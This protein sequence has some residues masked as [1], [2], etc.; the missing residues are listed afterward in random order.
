MPD[1]IAVPE[2]FTSGAEAQ[3]AR[4]H[5]QAERGSVPEIT[6]DEDL[7]R[8]DPGTKYRGPDNVVRTKPFIIKDDTDFAKVPEGAQYIGPDDVLRTKP[9][10]E[11]IGFT[12]QT[13]YGMAL[14][15]QGREK[16]LR[17]VYGDKVRKDDGGLYVD[18]DGKLRRPGAR[19]I[20]SALGV[21]AAETLP[22]VGMTVGSGLGGV[23]GLETGPGAAG[24]AFGG[25][26]L[27]AML[28][29]QANNLILGLAGIHESLPVQIESI[30]TEGAAVAGGEVLGKTATKTIKALGALP[31]IN[32][33]IRNAGE[34]IKGGITENLAG[35]LQAVGIT[36]ERA[37]FLGGTTHAAAQQAADITERFG[38][39]GIVA[40]SN[41]LPEAPGLKKIEEFD[42]VFRAQNPFLQN[43]RALYEQDT[44]RIAESPEIG[45]NITEPFTQA[46]KGVSSRKAGEKVLESKL[47]EKA[48]GDAE[49]ENAARDAKQ[50]FQAPITAEG[51]EKA[52]RENQARA[53]AI[54]QKRMDDSAKQTQEL[55]TGMVDDLHADVDKAITLGKSGDDPSRLVREVDA[56]FRAYNAAIRAQASNMYNAADAAA[57]N[58][59]V[60]TGPLYDTAREF[61]ASMPEAL[62]SKYPAEVA[63]L[64]KLAGIGKQG[65]E[66]GAELEPQALTFGELR[67]LRSWFRYGIDYHDLTPD[68]K[69]GSL[70]FFEK[71]IN[72]VIHD[73]EAIPALKDAAGLLD[74]ADAFYKANIPFMQDQMV[75]GIVKSLKSG[76]GINPAGVADILFVPG[77]TEALRRARDILGEN[78]WKSVEAAHINK[79]LDNSKLLDGSID[80]VKFAKQVTEDHK[81]GL[82]Q[83]GY[84]VS[85]AARITKI[86]QDI[87]RVQGTLPI[88]PEEVDSIASLMQAAEA[89]KKEMEIRAEQDPL[90]VLSR[91][92]KRIDK[93]WNAAQKTLNAQRKTDPLGFT[94][95]PSAL[96][97]KSA[98]RILGSPDLLLAAADQ[99]GTDSIEFNALRQVFVSRFF[100]R[101]IGR[102]GGLRGELAG[103]LRSPFG[104]EGISD[105]MQ[106]LLFPGTTREQL[107]TLAKDMEFLFS[108]RG[109]SMGGAMAAASR[110]LNP[111]AHIPI[112]MPTGAAKFFAS[113]PGVSF[114]HRL[115]LGKMYATI[116]DGVSHPNFINWLAGR[117]N[118]TPQERAV[119]R[120]V[121]QE[122]LKLGGWAG[123]AFL[124]TRESP[125]NRPEQVQ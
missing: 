55:L 30:G 62:L 82:L 10:Y 33:G 100:Q 81:N 68:M 47:R 32:Q 41:L 56:K 101:G 57:G 23:A 28:G 51:G 14:T 76:V 92:T 95:Q 29:R 80:A 61:V 65:A 98:D 44:K 116:M 54:L 50:A 31:A 5:R 45:L 96:A 84:S 93:E 49:L 13:L 75:K 16:A 86:A 88:R 35:I 77:R 1:D 104:K 7:A 89:A 78:L 25:G 114:V 59:V 34:Q 125:E 43:T 39:G 118:G 103:E 119:A 17:T 72:D 20:K 117:L 94:F 22:A 66:E 9:T 115:L 4:Y 53:V 112:P 83:T 91:E 48:I 24:T 70:K 87:E 18:D 2:G 105:E 108:G 85:N 36:P 121:V 120:A 67:K 124:Q 15:D 38:K 107:V 74:K 11:P 123:S 79:M 6:G 122:R 99:F 58:N 90:G 106:A 27:G 19:D 52:V 71:K 60:N 64:R 40:P 12:A 69:E 42:S 21:S 3:T 37:R 102:I 8:I 46:T 26:V 110:V 63:I 73:A 113:V 97:I 111:S 109:E